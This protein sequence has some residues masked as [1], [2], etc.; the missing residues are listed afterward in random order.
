MKGFY[1]T[2][3]FFMMC[4]HAQEKTS[5]VLKLS[6]LFGFWSG[7]GAA[8]VLPEELRLLSRRLKNQT[9]VLYSLD[10]L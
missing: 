4:T 9:G 5:N 1:V 3:I 8:Y 10:K 2:L 7:A 6:E